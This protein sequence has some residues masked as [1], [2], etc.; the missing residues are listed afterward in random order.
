MNVNV[1]RKQLPS[2]VTCFYLIYLSIFDASRI[3][4]TI[5]FILQGSY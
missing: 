2:S 3:V 1:G 5:V 4:N